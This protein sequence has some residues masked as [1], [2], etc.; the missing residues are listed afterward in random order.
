MALT[1]F[2]GQGGL[3]HVLIGAATWA[4][5]NG[6]IY[7]CVNEKR[8]S[9]VDQDLVIY[10]SSGGAPVEVK[11]YVGGVDSQS[12]FTQGGVVVDKNGTLWVATSTTLPGS[13]TGTGFEAVWESIPGFDDACPDSQAGPP[14]PPGDSG[15]P[16]PSGPPGPPGIPGSIGPQG[17]Q[18]P[19]GVT[20]PQGPRGLTGPACQC[21]ENCTS[22]QP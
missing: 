10:R 16:G 5:C 21:C 7:F 15:A 13:T 4:H 18:G 1:P 20:G 14:G 19:M 3:E 12:A 11:R 8:G 22:S 17:L 2:P 9:G 6:N